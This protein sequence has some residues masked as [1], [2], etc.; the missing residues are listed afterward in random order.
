MLKMSLGSAVMAQMQALFG[1]AREQSKS[2]KKMGF[3][4]QPRYSTKP[5]PIHKSLTKRIATGPNSYHEHDRVVSLRL[6]GL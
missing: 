6:A 1:A 2:T 4:P 3:K 5:K